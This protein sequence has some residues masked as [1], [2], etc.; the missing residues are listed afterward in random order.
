[1]AMTEAWKN[2]ALD[3]SVTVITHIALLD[4]TNTELSGGSYA[5]KAVTWAAASGGIVRPNADIEFDVPASTTVSK[6]A[7]Y[8]ALT[9]GTKYGED[10][11]TNEVFANA[12]T[13]T[14]LAASTGIQLSDPT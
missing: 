13:Y 10:D 4:E 9:D 2:Q 3:A 11:V 14:L 6:I 1:M 8:S 5:R 12:G 7:Y